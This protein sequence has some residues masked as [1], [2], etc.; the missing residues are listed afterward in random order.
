MPRSSFRRILVPHD[1]SAEADQAMRLAAKLPDCRE[2]IVLHVLEPYYGPVDPVYSAMIPPPQAL[3]PEQRALLERRVRRVVGARRPRAA[4]RVVVGKAS[5]QIVKAAAGADL[6]VMP[7]TG[8]TGLTHVLIGS[9]AERVVRFSPTPVLTIR[10]R[11]RGA[12]RARR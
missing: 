9:V 1:F 8:R 7:T 11:R 10:T 2:L 3:I 5:E 12:R 6:V 4:V